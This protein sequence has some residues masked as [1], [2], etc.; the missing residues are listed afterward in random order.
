MKS[1]TQEPIN[2]TSI[3]ETLGQAKNTLAGMKIVHHEIMESQAIWKARLDYGNDVKRRLESFE[4]IDMADKLIHQAQNHIDFL[5]KNL[6]IQQEKI[7]LLTGQLES[8]KTLPCNTHQIPKQHDLVDM[9]LT[10]EKQPL[11][12]EGSSV[13]ESAGYRD[14]QQAMLSAQALIELRD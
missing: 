5:T 9:I 4:D 10:M 8:L 3:S 11:E 2:D 14:I 1:S 7:V 12:L 13:V 6:N